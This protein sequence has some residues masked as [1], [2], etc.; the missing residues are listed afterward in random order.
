MCR[1]LAQEREYVIVVHGGAG[2]MENLEDDKEKSTLYYAALDSALSIGNAILSAGG[3]GPEAVMAVVNYFENNPLFNAGK[4][5]TCTSAGTFELDASIMEGKDLTAGAVA[6]L[7]TVKN[8]INAAYAV[9][10]K[11][12]T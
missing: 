8:P 7:K 1:M 3:E 12:L 4:G 6:G 9:K 2:A 11:H 10:L 5:A